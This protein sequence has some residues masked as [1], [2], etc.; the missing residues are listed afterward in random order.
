MIKNREK[1]ISVAVVVIIIIGFGSTWLFFKIYSNKTSVGSQPYN[2]TI[3]YYICGDDSNS[4]K[5]PVFNA[6]KEAVINTHGSLDV[7]LTCLYDGYG[8]NGLNS[9]TYFYNISSDNYTE[10]DIGEK[11]MGN[12]TTL[13]DFLNFSQTAFPADNYALIINGQGSGILHEIYTT[14]SE[15]GGCI[16]DHSQTEEHHDY[17]NS[18]EIKNAVQGKN[19]N[20]LIFHSCVMGNVEFLYDLGDCADFFVISEETTYL[21]RGDG[22]FSAF[23]DN[24]KK[25]PLISP[26]ELGIEFVKEYKKS[27]P[28]YFLKGSMAVIKTKSFLL[29]RDGIKDICN[30]I[31]DKDL[32]Y[33]V[34]FSRTHAYQMGTQYNYTEHRYIDLLTFL[35]DT[36]EFAHDD[37]LDEIVVDLDNLIK[38]NV[39]YNSF[40]GVFDTYY[41]G[42]SIYFPEF[43]NQTFLEV[44][45]SDNWNFNNSYSWNSFLSDYY[46][47]LE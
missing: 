36:A 43:E 1:I 10:T 8:N 5:E 17:L 44:Y 21:E 19:I 15:I 3:M 41:K 20:L 42:L 11:N 4:F 26:E 27:H 7:G 2:W 6:H 23:I 16:F 40:W 14:E 34:E 13:E 29:I 22:T 46:N 31:K 33:S 38:N 45:G 12:Q 37:G 35:E 25:N 47:S 18:S 32:F 24:V 30:Y 28:L 9:S 39:I